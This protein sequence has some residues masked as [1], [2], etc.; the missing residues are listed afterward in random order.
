MICKSVWLIIKSGDPKEMK[1]ILLITEDFNEM[2]FIETLL[3]KLGF[4]T[5]GTQ[6]PAAALEKAMN[7]NPDMIILSDVIKGQSTHVLLE[8][9]VGYRPK[10]FIVLMKSD[11][12]SKTQHIEE[13]VN[14][15]VK[16]PIDPVDFIQKICEVSKL[17][18][19]QYLEKFYKLGL[20]KGTPDQEAITVSGKY[21]PGSETQFVKNLKNAVT[22]KDSTSRKKRF[23]EQIKSLSEPKADKMD[24]KIAHK[25]AQEYRMRSKDAEIVKIDE[26]RQS[27]VKALFK[28]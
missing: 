5:L 23:S 26:Q 17:N 16:S 27:F 3:K 2:T 19:A 14:G 28:K 6:N 8:S 20:F 18:P 9:L 22:D 10:M 24:H 4:D 12:H 25:E 11:V 1:R 15:V 21:K 13:F 7:I